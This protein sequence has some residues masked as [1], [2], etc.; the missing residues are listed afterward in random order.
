MISKEKWV[1]L[2]HPAHF[3]CSDSCRFVLATKVG[4]YI[5][6]TVGEYVPDE[7]VREIHCQVYGIKLVGMG[8]ARLA[9]YMK[10][11]GYQELGVA[12]TY[13]T[14][15]FK[16]VKDR[17]NKCCGWKISALEQLDFSGYNNPEQARK[18]HYMLCNKW[19]KKG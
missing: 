15:V 19:S 8:Y 3:I 10:K 18:G 12:R 1:W 7:P 13:E 11:V 17:E 9:D 2:P 4:R 5:V 14:M 16:C 6:S